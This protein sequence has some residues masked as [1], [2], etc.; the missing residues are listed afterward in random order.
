M[1]GKKIEKNNVTISLYVFYIKKEKIYPAYVLPL[2]IPNGN[3]WHYVVLKNLS[4]LLT[5][6]KSKHHG[7]FYCLNCLHSFAAEKKL[8][9][10]KSYIKIKS[11]AI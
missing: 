10:I 8:N 3:G 9:C 11:F 5:G 4:A 7:G 2:I 6:I 1:I